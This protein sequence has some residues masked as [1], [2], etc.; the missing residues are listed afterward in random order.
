MCATLT[1]VGMPTNPC[2]AS[3]ATKL[4]SLK[5]TCITDLIMLQKYRRLHR[6]LEHHDHE[7]LKCRID[8]GFAN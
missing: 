6:H 3:L 5:S 4:C 2:I 8:Q 7:L 1:V